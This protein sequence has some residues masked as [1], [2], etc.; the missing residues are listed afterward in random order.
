M[1]RD[2][3]EMLGELCAAGVEFLVVGAYA[4]STHGRED[5]DKQD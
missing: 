2:F 3:D 4:L 1:N 5:E